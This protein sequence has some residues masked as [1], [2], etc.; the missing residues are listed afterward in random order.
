MYI[1]YLCNIT[2]KQFTY[3][4]RISPVFK[5]LMEEIN[6]TDVKIKHNQHLLRKI[7]N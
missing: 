4:S 5:K 1:P 3:V 6:K 2:L 7:K